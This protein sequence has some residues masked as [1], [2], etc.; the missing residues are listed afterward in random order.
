MRWYRGLSSLTLIV[1][2]INNY[3]PREYFVLYSSYVLLIVFVIFTIFMLY[4]FLLLLILFTQRLWLIMCL[5]SLTRLRRRS[6]PLPLLRASTRRQR[7]RTVARPSVV[8]PISNCYLGRAHTDTT[9][10]HADRSTSIHH[11]QSLVQL[12]LKY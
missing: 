7:A 10:A 1:D 2:L 9:N 11:T 3:S 6:R 8:A 4:T 5:C 12:D